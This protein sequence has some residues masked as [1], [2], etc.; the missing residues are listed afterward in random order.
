M[1]KMAEVE[2]TVADYYERVWSRFVL[3]WEVEKTLGLHYALYD[4]GVK[5]FE[6]AVFNMSDYVGKL[7][8]LDA[9]T[10]MNVLDAGCGVGGTSIYLA[11]KYPNLNF[12][13]ITITPGQLALANK[14][15]EERQVDNTDFM[16]G[17][18]LKTDFPDHNFNNVFALESVSYALNKKNFL[19][20]MHRIL[21]PRGRLAVIDT[22]F[23]SSPNNFFMKKLH[24]LTCIG[25]G[26]PVDDDLILND[27]IS[28]MRKEGFKNI[29]AKNLSRNVAR[30]Q[31]RSFIIGI[32]FF[33]SSLIKYIIT[34]GRCDLSKDS[35][36][37]LGTS[38]L[39][40]LYGL[41]GAGKYYSVTAVKN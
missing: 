41:T 39:C 5:T 28:Q 35:N 8:D 32:P 37:Y 4:K 31:L 25:R 33:F 3:W 7:L 21:K 36:Y 15:A 6:Q 40:A 29:K 13:G 12:T 11:K 23:I 27:F 2:E 17:N 20:E 9:S 34:R 22:F 26:V 14:F 19:K 30:S 38:V 1:D 24:D 18:Y 10:E 16:L